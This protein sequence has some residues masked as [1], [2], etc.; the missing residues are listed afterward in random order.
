VV[1]EK[2][3]RQVMNE[4]M[5]KDA[6]E[7]LGVLMGSLAYSNPS[8]FVLQLS[9]FFPTGAIITCVLIEKSASG[10]IPDA[11]EIPEVVA[12]ESF[13]SEKSTFVKES[14]GPKVAL[15][16]DHRA[17]DELDKLAGHKTS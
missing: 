15:L 12:F 14:S 4:L 16:H 7:T 10:L 5:G 6:T 8:E 1:F 13:A 2:T 11:K 17:E 9:K 3:A